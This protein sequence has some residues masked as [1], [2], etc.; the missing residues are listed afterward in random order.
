MLMAMRHHMCSVAATQLQLPIFMLNFTWHS[1]AHYIVLVVVQRAI[2]DAMHSYK[3]QFI[4]LITSQ[5]SIFYGIF[6]L[7][8][9]HDEGQMT[10][11]QFHCASSFPRSIASKRNWMEAL[12]GAQKWIDWRWTLHWN[13]FLRSI[14]IQF[15]V[16][17]RTDF[18]PYRF[19]FRRCFIVNR[20]SGMGG[21]GAHIAFLAYLLLNSGI[22]ISQ[23]NESKSLIPSDVVSLVFCLPNTSIVS[24]LDESIFGAHICC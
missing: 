11:G 18:I 2:A 1:V 10:F 22:K 24:S 20:V 19:T 13:P 14:L 8:G 16:S 6:D 5:K 12:L 3:I 15:S 7:F 4:Q 9:V 23:K 21:G 17:V